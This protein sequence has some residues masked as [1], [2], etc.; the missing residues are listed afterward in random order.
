MNILIKSKENKFNK[1]ELMTQAI[2]LSESTLRPIT[3]SK[4]N[5]VIK[6]QHSQPAIVGTTYPI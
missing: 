1:D 2:P 5:S 3:C 6:L 4:M